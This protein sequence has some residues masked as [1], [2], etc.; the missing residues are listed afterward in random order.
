M[1][2]LKRLPDAE[3]EIME[4][5]WEQTGP[6]TANMIMEVMY[7]KDAKIRKAQTIHTLLTRLVERGAVNSEK[8][9]KERYFTP[10][11]KRE[12]YLQFETQHFMKQYYSGSCFNL[13]NTMYQGKELSNDDLEELI[14]W[15]DEQRKRI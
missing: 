11:I 8:N 10:L 12:E 3:F 13:I 14:K 5:I 4:V 9:G 1:A 6:V 2:P 7:R 15:A